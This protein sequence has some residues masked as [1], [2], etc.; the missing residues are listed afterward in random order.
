MPTDMERVMAALKVIERLHAMLEERGIQ[1][2]GLA[3][4][5]DKLS[6]GGGQLV[7]YPQRLDW[8]STIFQPLPRKEGTPLSVRVEIEAS[9][10]VGDGDFVTSDRLRY[11]GPDGGWYEI[12]RK[13]TLPEIDR[14]LAEPPNLDEEQAW[15]RVGEV[16][17]RFAA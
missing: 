3:L 4:L 6:F 5:A 7:D 14:L 15:R 1:E 10:Y 16:L 12:P 13:A 11:T 17:S 9:E 2:G 8:S